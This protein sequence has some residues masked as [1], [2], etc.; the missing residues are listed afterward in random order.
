MAIFTKDGIS[1]RLLEEKDLPVITA[2]RNDESTWINLGNPFPVKPGLQKKWLE[3]I[4]GS[5]DKTYLAA[6]VQEGALVG[7]VRMDEYDPV[8]RSIRVGVDVLP[9]KRRQGYGTAIYH[10]LLDYLTSHL[11]IHRIWL[12]VLDSNKAAQ[13]LYRNVGFVQEG[14]MREAVWRNGKYQ[15]YLLMSVLSR[16]RV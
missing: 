10:A 9:E 12:L 7:M 5:L 13:K 2:L 1:L 3:S 14:R 4:H 6:E 15:D 8:N 11:N 16:D